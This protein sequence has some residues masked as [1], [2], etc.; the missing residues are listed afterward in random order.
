M[1]EPTG[2]PNASL[3]AMAAGPPVV[4][5]DAGDMC[6]QVEDGVTARLIGREDVAG[7]AAAVVE[8]A[9]NLDRRGSSREAGMNRA[10]ERFGLDCM[11][12][13]FRRVSLDGIEHGCDPDFRGVLRSA[14]RRAT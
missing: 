12:T 13:D 4:A 10:A 1:A 7:L 14:R 6:E 2:C 3:E 11:V 5:T 9:S 8:A